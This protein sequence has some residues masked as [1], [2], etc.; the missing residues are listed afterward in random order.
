MN[1]ACP[2]GH[3]GEGYR[4]RRDGT[5]STAKGA[6]QLYL[7]VSADGKHHRFRGSFVAIGDDAPVRQPDEVRC[8]QGHRDAKIQSRGIRKSLTGTWRRYTCVRP[9]GDEHSFRLML[10]G[11]DEEPV[12]PPKTPAPACP[13]HP[14]SKVIRAGTYGKRSRRQRYLC[15]PEDGK[16]HQFTPPLSREAVSPGESCKRCDELLSPHHGPISAARH[17]PWTLVG[18]A[19]ALSN[20]SLGESYANVSLALRAQRDAAH[21]H[22]HAEH[23]IEFEVIP[24]GPGAAIASTSY[25]RKQRRN[26][27]RVAADLVEQYSPPLFAEVDARYRAEAQ[28]LRDANDAALAAAPGSALRRPLVYILDELPIWTQER[29]DRPKRPSWNVLTAVEIR[30][31]PSA[32]PFGLPERDV[33]LRLARAFPRA[34]SDAWQLVLA[35]LDVRPDFVVS[36]AGSGLQAALKAFYGTT[37]G[38]IPSLWHIHSNVREVLLKL[39][40]ATFLDGGEQ[41]LVDPLR[42]HLSRLGRDELIGRTGDEITAWWDDMDAIIA[43]LPAPVSVLHGQRALHEP[44][45]LAALPILTANPHVPA[46]NAAVENRIRMA[47]KPFLEQRSHLFGNA[48]RTN[49]LLNLLVCRQAGVFT[50]LDALTLRI[51]RM[52]EA[53]GGWAPAPRQ[54][55]DKQPSASKSRTARY[56][57]LKAHSVIAK[58]AKDKGI[59]TTAQVKAAAPMPLLSRQRPETVE[60]LPIREWARSVG[61]PAGVTGP[62]RASVHAAYAA[63]EGGGT[64]E[65]ARAVF[66]RAEQE[67]YAKNHKAKKAKWSRKAERAR[68]AELAPVRAWAAE[69]GIALPANN[70]IPASVIEAY[71]AAQQGKA[72]PRRPSKRPPKATP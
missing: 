35:E 70:L 24:S 15:K 32:D 2:K 7:C 36:D 12:V 37:V 57:S 17:T 59:K 62:I 41:V 3:A 45:L 23:G 14:G 43:G 42:K 4:I 34:N 28:A 69:N 60:R 54:I 49:R 9:N 68:K 6:K 56:E 48:E 38:L 8:P 40:N 13:E 53:T 47:L 55:L 46:S 22:L 61:L 31:E 29:A 26:A 63:L 25:S 18:V 5:A 20:L 67:R 30:W 71:E 65:E 64:D 27:W 11:P 39:P 51:R 21:Q 58:L 33:R 66:D 44:R 50:D 10:A 72:A 52:N 19:Q 16:A 1:I